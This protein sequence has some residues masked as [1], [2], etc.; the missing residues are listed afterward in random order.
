MDRLNHYAIN[1]G[2]DREILGEISATAEPISSLAGAEAEIHA[3][4]LRDVEPEASLEAPVPGSGDSPKPKATA[5][6]GFRARLIGGL[7]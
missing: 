7:G 2:L 1:A 3:K 6:G 5:L 4:L